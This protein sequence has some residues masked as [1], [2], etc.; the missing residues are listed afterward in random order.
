M[1]CTKS[2]K[3][4]EKNHKKQVVVDIMPHYPKGFPFRTEG[5]IPLDAGWRGSRWLRFCAATTGRCWGVKAH[6]PCPRRGQFWR[7]ASELL[8]SISWDLVDSASWPNFSLIPVFLFLYL[9]LLIPG[10]LWDKPALGLPRRSTWELSYQLE[11][12]WASQFQSQSRIVSKKFV[13]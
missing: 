8:K 13:P 7:A 1:T 10:I 3:N 5:F 12:F 4:F 2:M 9:W 6:L 11:F